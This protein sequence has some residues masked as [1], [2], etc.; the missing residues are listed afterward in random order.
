MYLYGSSINGQTI[1]E[2]ISA[3]R[4]GGRCKYVNKNKLNVIDFKRK[5]R[6]VTVYIH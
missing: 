4:N 6:Y 2:K 1:R 5:P 3:E